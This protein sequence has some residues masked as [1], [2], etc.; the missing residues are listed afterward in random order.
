MPLRFGYHGGESTIDVCV[1]S[2]IYKLCLA[3]WE[4]YSSWNLWKKE[5]WLSHNVTIWSTICSYYVQKQFCGIGHSFRSTVP[6][7]TTK[8]KKRTM[9]V[10]A[11]NNKVNSPQ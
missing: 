2:E 6:H 7:C 4:G 3:S 5:Q 11:M 1:L 9:N 10:F 8:K